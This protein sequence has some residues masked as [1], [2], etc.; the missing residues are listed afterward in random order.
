MIGGDVMAAVQPRSYEKYGKY[1][2]RKNRRREKKWGK[3]FFLLLAAAAVAVII[4][5]GRVFV[6]KEVEVTGNSAFGQSEVTGLSGISL[7]MSI[8]KVDA[9]E[10]ERNFSTNRYVELL[11]VETELPD[12]VKITIRE[13][14]PRAA[15]NCAGVILVV[16]E[17]G[18]ILERRTTVPD[19]DGIVVVSGINASVN[20]QSTHIESEM[21]GQTA[22]MKKMLNAIREEQVNGLISELN[23]SNPDNIYLISE[24]GI[25]VLIGD[26]ER[27]PEKFVWM[28]AV[29]EELTNKGVMRGVLDVSSGKNAVYAER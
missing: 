4:F 20:S 15:I 11:K 8:F 16:D 23:V 14:T 26:E 17:E 13:R 3:G 21:I 1:I 24:T 10:V 12:K 9:E 27:L 22:L 28:R 5:Q 7:G 18:C 2:N 19:D 6:V 25:Q 29:L